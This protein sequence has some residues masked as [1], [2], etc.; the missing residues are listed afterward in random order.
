MSDITGVEASND[1]AIYLRLGLKD[2]NPDR[3]AST[4]K[5]R[6]M[7]QVAKNSGLSNEELRKVLNTGSDLEFF[8]MIKTLKALGLKIQIVPK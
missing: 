5:M 1:I 7:A 3:L 2:G 6:G 8:T 4:I